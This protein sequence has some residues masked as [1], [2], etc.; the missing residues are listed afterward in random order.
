V[1]P[2]P[3]DPAAPVGAL[4][5][6]LAGHVG[7]EA[8]VALACHLLGG[9]DRSAYPQELP[10][11]TRL[12]DTDGHPVEWSRVWGARALLYVWDD[13]ATDAVLAGMRDP[14]WRVSEMCLKVGVRRE[15]GQGADVAAELVHHELPRV[16][17]HAVRLLGAAGDTEHVEVVRDALDDPDGDVR[18]HAAR[19]LDLMADRL[20]L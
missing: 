18:R 20:D 2:A 19:A 10:Y 11:L 1:I 16:R 7:E 13:A 12:A 17:G 5:G 14:F 3:R 15:L 6:E 4:V 8:V 9:A